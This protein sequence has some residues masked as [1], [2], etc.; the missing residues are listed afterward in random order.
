MNETKQKELKE[1][2]NGFKKL[3]KLSS[4]LLEEEIQFLNNLHPGYTL[5]Q[6]A[7]LFLVDRETPKCLNC[8]SP[9]KEIHREFCCYK[10]R[11]RWDSKNQNNTISV[12]VKNKYGVAS[13][14]HIPGTIEKGLETKIK[15]YGSVLSSSHRKKLSELAATNLNVIGRKT[16][17]E[18][19]GVENPGQ[20]LDHREKCKKTL[21]KNY[22][23]TSFN[24]SSEYLEKKNLDRL[25]RWIKLVDD[26]EKVSVIEITDP[27]VKLSEKYVSPNKRLKLRCEDHGEFELPYE[28]YKYRIANFGTPCSGC[29][30]VT[31]M[32]SRSMAENEI[33]EYIRSLLPNNKIISNDRH[34]IHP[35][36]LDIYIPDRKLAIE[37][38]GLFWHSELRK[39]KDYHRR[40]YLAC[41]EQG[42]Q[43]ITIFEDEWIK[44]KEKVKSRI[45]YKLRLND[46]KC[47][48][49]KCSVGEIKY[50][51]YKEFV[52]K[53]HIQGSLPASVYLGLKFQGELV[54]VMS[55]SKRKIHKTAKVSSEKNQFELLRFCSSA[56]VIGGAGR[57]FAYFVKN[58]S[59]DKIISYSDLRWNDGKVYENIGMTYNGD[60]EVNYW[61]TDMTERKHRYGFRK[62]PHE[63]RNIT[64][65]ELRNQEGWFKIWDCGNARYV[66]EK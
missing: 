17:K 66:W 11:S 24:Q 52:D 21:M 12:N 2:L 51:E 53:N 45:R 62:K 59:P 8:D 46:K 14:A 63:P 22:G 7:R 16:L 28:T 49:R 31:S 29:C 33:F 38:C 61:Y 43:L 10:C 39:D 56:N 64:E 36:E 60:T 65:H 1:K 3:V 9:V 54:S 37:Y 35:N 6:Q 23:V 34:L 20:L 57:L 5:V 32:T 27:D 4:R 13:T 18:K 44:Q 47:Y 58:Y 41:L 42:V 30:G 26:I 25:E 50:S 19:Y 40:K 55:F 48:A 15:K